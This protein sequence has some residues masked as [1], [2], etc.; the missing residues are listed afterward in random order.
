[1]QCSWCGSD[2]GGEP[3]DGRISHGICPPCA[4]TVRA[5]MRW[6]RASRTLDAALADFDARQVAA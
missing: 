3:V 4:E 2:L 5:D 1:M 6:T